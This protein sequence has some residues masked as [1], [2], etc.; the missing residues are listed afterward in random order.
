MGLSGGGGHINTVAHNQSRIA[1]QDLFCIC[2][3]V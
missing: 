2:E 1:Y 3:V